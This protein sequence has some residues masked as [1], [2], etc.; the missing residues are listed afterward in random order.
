MTAE[1]ASTIQT[2][3][4]YYYISVKAICDK[5]VAK[6]TDCGKKIKALLDEKKIVPSNIIKDLLDGFMSF[7]S[8]QNVDKF[9]IDGILDYSEA[10]DGFKKNFAKKVNIQGI[11]TLFGADEYIL[12]QIDTLVE[13]QK[14]AVQACYETYKTKTL[15]V[16]ESAEKEFKT[17]K[18]DISSAALCE[19]AVNEI[20][21]NF[22]CYPGPT[23]G[24]ILCSGMTGSGMNT[25]MKIIE[26]SFGYAVIN[27]TE[28]LNA[29]SM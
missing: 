15:S 4:N 3:F 11:V 5:E 25:Q 2:K 28:V 27:P 12:S 20:S 24:V 26:E 17:A 10:Y 1:V 9:V 8:S 14:I 19:A 16:I 18:I 29:A 23:P 7:M 13:E 6:D 22:G 21:S